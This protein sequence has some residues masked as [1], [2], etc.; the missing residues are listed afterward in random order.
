M[1]TFIQGCP[2]Q[3]VLIGLNPGDSAEAVPNVVRLYPAMRRA[4]C[5]KDGS[6]FCVTQT[7]TNYEST[8]GTLTLTRLEDFRNT[9]TSAFP[10]SVACT[11]CRKAG[12]NIINQTKPDTIEDDKLKKLCGDSF[13]NGTTPSGI[14]G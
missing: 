2:E 7:L 5:L 6:T 8:V 11:N 4:L 14:T 9:D 12:Y 13:I 3:V 1:T 10:A